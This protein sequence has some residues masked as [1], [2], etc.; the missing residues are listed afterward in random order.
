MEPVLLSLDS[1]EA[2]HVLEEIDE[3]F[4]AGLHGGFHAM[5]ETLRTVDSFLDAPF[6]FFEIEGLPALGAIECVCTLKRTE[7]LND[8]LS[9]L[10]AFQVNL[11]A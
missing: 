3:L 2:N 7:R 8:L 6:D 5:L 10:R 1:S 4:T 11:A 9:A